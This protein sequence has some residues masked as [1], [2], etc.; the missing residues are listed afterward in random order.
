MIFGPASSAVKRLMRLRSL[1]QINSK[2]VLAKWCSRCLQGYGLFIA[3]GAFIDPTVSLPHPIGIVIG[4]GVRIERGVRIYQNVTI[5]GARIG[6]YE[7]NKYPSIGENTVLFAGCVIVGDI[8]VGRNC[9]I[10]ANSVV[11]Q[12]VPDGSVAVGAPARV[13][14]RNGPAPRVLLSDE[15]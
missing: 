12:D 7:G 3:P 13:V 4:N 14:G 2:P 10:G 5:G 11:L 8:S 15:A 1:A 9:T 6:D